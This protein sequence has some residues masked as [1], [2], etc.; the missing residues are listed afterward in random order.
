MLQTGKP[1]LRGHFPF[2]EPQVEAGESPRRAPVLGPGF[3]LTRQAE[4]PCLQRSLHPA[5]HLSNWLHLSLQ[6]H[7]A[8]LRWPA[9]RVSQEKSPF[10]GHACRFSCLPFFFSFILINSLVPQTFS[11][12][13]HSSFSSDLTSEP[14]QSHVNAHMDHLTKENSRSSSACQSSSVDNIPPFGINISN[15]R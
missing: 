14:E 12:K 2:E 9:H 10:S 13:Q 5:P 6:G 7:E 11:V 1:P 8:R 3:S 4:L 15:F